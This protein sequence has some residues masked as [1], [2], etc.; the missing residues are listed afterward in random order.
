VSETDSSEEVLGGD[1]RPPTI[2]PDPPI[3][4]NLTVI[5]CYDPRMTRRWFIF[6]IGIIV[7]LLAIPLIAYASIPGP[8]GVIHA[9]YKNT[10]GSTRIIDSSACCP[11]G[12]TALNWNQVGPSGPPG[13]NG[14]NGVSGYEVVSE[15]VAADAH[16]HVTSCPTGKHALSGGLEWHPGL[17]GEPP[18]LTNEVPGFDHITADHTG[19]VF[20]YLQVNVVY[21]FDVVCALTG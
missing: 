1:Y 5:T 14:T 19:W 3:K 2:F 16:Q 9:C 7:T 13:V 20:Y 11:N 15:E 10:D 18:N 8:D 12:Y 17:Y 4:I 6:L 21:T